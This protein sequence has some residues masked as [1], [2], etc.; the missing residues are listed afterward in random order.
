MGYKETNAYR[1]I[2]IL[3]CIINFSIKNKLLTALTMIKHVIYLMYKL[4]L[5]INI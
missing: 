5:N 4:L 3:K 1:I 2:N